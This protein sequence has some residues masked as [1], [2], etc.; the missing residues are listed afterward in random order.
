M[1]TTL[2][3]P[4]SD[5][6]DLLFNAQKL[7]E[8]V[9]GP[10]QYYTDRLGANHRT[11]A[12]INA[13]ANIVLGGIGYA[14][15]VAYA[16]GISMTLT[17]QTVEYSGE[18]YS[19]KV[20]N[21]PFTTST[22]ATDSAKFRLIQ[23]VTA[24]DLSSPNGSELIGH[25]AQGVGAIPTTVSSALRISVNMAQF[26]I[27]DGSDETS[28]VQNAINAAAGKTLHLES[29]KI[30]GIT[31]VNIPDNVT[32]ISNGSSFR[33][34]AA[35]SSAA[36]TV[37]KNFKSDFFSLS[38][39]GSSVDKG[40]RFTGGGSKVDRVVCTSDA[41]DSNYGIQFQSTDGTSLENISIGS[42]KVL[43]FKS[44]VLIYYVGLSSFNNIEVNTYVTGV[45]LRDVYSTNFNGASISL[46]SPSATGSAGQ[47]GLLVESTLSSSSTNNLRI[48]NWSV[49]N[50][51]EHAYRFGGQLQIQDVWLTNCRATLPGNSGAIATGGSGFKI[52][53]ATYDQTQ[54]HRDFFLDNCIVEDVSTIG[55][56]IGNF[57]GFL[58]SVA[59]N[60][61]I[62]NCSVL[63]RGNTYS[64]WHGY[65]LDSVTGV[66]LTNNYCDSAKQHAIRVTASYLA[67]YPATDGVNKNINIVG[68]Y[69][70]VDNAAVSSVLR[71]NADGA[72]TPGTVEGM[73]I[74]GASFSGG[75]AAVR[76]ETG[77]TYS[78]NYFNLSYVD[79]NAIAT[80]PPLL[81]SNDITYDFIGPWSTAY[82]PSGANG[83]TYKDVTNGLVKIR[84]AGS[85]VTL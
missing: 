75:N 79:G 13:S 24:T 6:T 63:R 62:S 12:G 1:T 70:G 53:G 52:L 72:S 16:A 43:N 35:S 31:S 39:P 5:P 80:Q 49:A 56:G 15:P 26:A 14:P 68:G 18:V 42:M 7:D 46:T 65:S 9:S 41:V 54:R 45:Y 83:S 55:N 44:A 8:V 10:E 34:L 50:S 25:T 78:K 76:A 33:K 51:P 4:S 71:L 28:K 48:T 19:P 27:G 69:Y 22:W 37:G 2:P 47:N 20:A 59:D 81:D 84:K 74:T 85:W 82:S 77:I 23:G 58:V 38:T 57:C 67:A 64:C 40:I 66:F 17:T 30:Y 29:G 11:M 32:L 3:V 61:H 73:K 36:I 60:I 21:L